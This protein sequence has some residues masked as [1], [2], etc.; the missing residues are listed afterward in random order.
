VCH[1]VDDDEDRVEHTVI[2][3]DEHALRMPF[4]RVRVFESGRLLEPEQADVTGAVQLML[5]RSTKS[6]QL[7]WA[8]A[9]LPIRLQLPYR[10]R[11]HVDLGEKPSHAALSRLDNLGFELGRSQ[12]QRSWPPSRRS[13]CLPC[14]G[15]LSA[16]GQKHLGSAGVVSRCRCYR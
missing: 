3:Y 12:Q 2:L 8:P 11:Y 13:S 10:K 6:L 16:L 1:P 4:A 7:E 14:W 15:Q 9:A 5:R